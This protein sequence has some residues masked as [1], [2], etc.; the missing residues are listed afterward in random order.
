M[1]DFDIVVH[2]LEVPIDDQW[3]PFQNVARPVHVDMRKPG[4]VEVWVERDMKEGAII[5]Y[6]VL[7]LRVFGT[8]Q[9][10]KDARYLNR[11]GTVLDRT[12]DPAGPL[13]WH[14]YSGGG[15]SKP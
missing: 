12:F 7:S 5:E 14:V 11:V 6:N 9:V 4:I 15:G 8:G 13:V 10:I 3:H 2:R 1:S